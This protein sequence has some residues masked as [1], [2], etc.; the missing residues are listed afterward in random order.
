MAKK[1]ISYS[2]AITEI[3]KI[4]NDIE[5]GDLNVDE[6]SEKIKRVSLLIKSCQKKLHETQIEVEKILEKI[7]E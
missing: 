4:V 2:D 5:N 6:I 1:E 3:E 7:D